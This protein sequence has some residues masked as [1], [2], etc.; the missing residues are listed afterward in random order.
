MIK[1]TC[2]SYETAT[3]LIRQTTPTALLPTTDLAMS[4]LALKDLAAS[5]TKKC[6]VETPT[7]IHKAMDKKEIIE[8]QL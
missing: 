6:H 4:G 2:R 5:T 7:H 1:K 3:I 8:E